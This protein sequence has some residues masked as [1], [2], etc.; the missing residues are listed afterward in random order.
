MSGI[1]ISY[2]DKL[3]KQD[4][5]KDGILNKR[6][7]HCVGVAK[8]TCE[9]IKRHNLNVD[10]NKAYVAGLLH[11]AT[12]L[13]DNDKQLKML[14]E[15]GYT[16]KDEIMLSPNVWHGETAYLYVQERYDINDSDVLNAIRYHVMGK[17]NMS[18][19]EMAVFVAD[20][21]EET[22]NGYV[23]EK[24]RE[25]EKEDLISSVVYILE[26]QIEFVNSK[27]Q[28]LISQT[29]KT[30]EYYKNYKKESLYE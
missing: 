26:S 15:L 25:I 29:L 11:D 23:F 13:L 18:P 9:I 12:K 3:L 16:D 30:Y 28:T 8:A 1:N 7:Y 24:A 14:Y 20:Y 27:K 6:Y 4:M 19:L 2:I 17:E 22:R 5:T 21:I 10:L